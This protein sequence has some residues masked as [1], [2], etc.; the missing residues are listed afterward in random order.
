MEI[1]GITTIEE[2]TEIITGLV[3]NG[4]TFVA[5]PAKDHTWNIEL[6]GGY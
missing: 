3:K 6:T 4:L 2:L 1:K 5:R